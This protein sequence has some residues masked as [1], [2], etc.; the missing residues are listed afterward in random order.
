MDA[1][2]G[3]CPL[4]RC[5]HACSLF[6]VFPEILAYIQLGNTADADCCGWHRILFSLQNVQD[7]RI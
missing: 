2:E 7:E 6:R 5:R 4:L 3:Y 1:D